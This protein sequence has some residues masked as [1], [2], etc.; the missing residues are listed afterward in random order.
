MT[1]LDCKADRLKRLP[2]YLFAAVDKKKEE[3][4]ARGVDLI[5][6]GVGDPDLPTPQVVLDALAETAK[7]PANHRYPSYS[8]LGPFKEAVARW[9]DRRFGVRLDPGKEVLSLIGSKEGIAHFP[10]AVLNPGDLALVPDPGYPVYHS[11]TIF[12]GGESYFLPLR[13]EKG[14]LPDLDAIPA[15]VARRAKIFFLNYPNNPTGA[16]APL[17]YY[18]QVVAFARKNDIWVASDAAYSEMYF[19]EKPHSFLEVPGA[20]DLAVEFH[21]CSKSY[22]MTGWRVGFVV[23]NASMIEALGDFKKNCDSGIFQAV[24]YA[25][26]A[27]LDKEPGVAHR[28]AE[29]K[30]R[31]D[32]LVAAL[33]KAGWPARPQPASFYLF[34]RYPWRCT[35]AEAAEKILAETGIV[36]TPGLGFGAC[37][38]GYVRFACTAPTDR[39]REA[40]RRLE[41]LR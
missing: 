15:D 41:G 13:E 4:L 19:Q 24:Q 38:E 16:V 39:V 10:L 20:K 3:A 1:V 2:P 12:A 29:Y 33:Q 9:Y 14:F 18:E 26:I 5:D 32:L 27:A 21:S 40:A 25:A 34:T 11:G 17:A 22:S 6:L 28:N 7:D 31:R 36:A 35:S 8:G 37:G 23:G 30:I